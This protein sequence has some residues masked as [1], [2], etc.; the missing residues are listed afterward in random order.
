MLVKAR[1]EAAQMVA[2]GRVNVDR[3][4]ELVLEKFR[5]AVRA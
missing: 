2:R 1:E 4:V 3:A 5:G